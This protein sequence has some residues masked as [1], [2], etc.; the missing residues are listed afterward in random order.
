M[1]TLFPLVITPRGA[2]AVAFY[3]DLFGMT[4]VA[5]IGWYVHLQQPDNPSMQLAFIEP[6]HDSVPGSHRAEPGGVVIT[7]EVDDVDELHARATEMGAPIHVPLRDEEWGQRHFITE[8]P[9]G[10]MVDVVTP[11]A[12][13][14]AFLAQLSAAR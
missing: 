11:I 13:S 3:R 5:D 14:P 8:D 6:G 1:K 2:D 7:L 12:P 4:V 10:L 9:T